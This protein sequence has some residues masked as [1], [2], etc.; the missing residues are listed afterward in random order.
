MSTSTTKPRLICNTWW[1]SGKGSKSYMQADAV[2]C[3]ATVQLQLQDRQIGYRQFGCYGS[4]DVALPC[5]EAM[6]RAPNHMFEIIRHGMMCKPYLDLDGPEVPAAFGGPAAGPHKV[7]ERASSLVRRIFLD[8]YGITLKPNDTIWLLSP[9]P[10]KLSLHLIIS[11]HSPQYVYKSNHKSDPG[12]AAHLAMRMKELDTDLAPLIDISVYSKDREMRAHRAFKYGKDPSTAL[13]IYSPPGTLP[14]ASERDVFITCLDDDVSVINVPITM[15][16]VV[17]RQRRSLRSVGEAMQRCPP[18]QHAECVTRMMDLLQ[19]HLHPTAYYDRGH[20]EEDPFNPAIAIKFNYHDRSELCYTGS[21]HAGC[22]NLRCWVDSCGDVHCKCFSDRCANHLPHRLGSLRAERDDYIAKA[23]CVNMEFIE[24]DPTLNDDRGPS[25]SDVDPSVAAVSRALHDWLNGSVKALSLRS[26]MGSGKT[27]FLRA[28]FLHFGSCF[29]TAFFP[30]YRQS[31]ASEHARKMEDH[32]FVS[33]LDVRRNGGPCSEDEAEDVDNTTYTSGDPLSDRARYPRVICSVE[34]MYR[35]ASEFEVPTF[36][37]VV[38]DESESL[39]RHWASKTVKG[40]SARM[41]WFI[42]MLCRARCIVMLDATWGALSHEFLERIGLSNILIINNRP[43]RVPRTFAFSKDEEA[44][45]GNIISDLKAGKKVAVA[46]L[47]AEHAYCLHRAVLDA[48]VS[49][50]LVLLHTSKTADN[51]R[52]GLRNVDALWSRYI[53]VIY[54]P[55]IA[56]GVDFSVEHFDR[57]YFY[58]CAGSALP[59]TALQMLFRVRKLADPAVSCCVSRTMR[60]GLTASSPALTSDDTRQW[61]LWMDA[62]M[63][64][65]IGGVDLSNMQTNFVRVSA[66]QGGRPQHRLL[67]AFTPLMGVLSFV[68]AE[69]HNA[70]KQYMREFAVLAEAGG[71]RV[72]T[73]ELPAGPPPVAVHEEEEKGASTSTTVAL[74]LEAHTRCPNPTTNDIKELERRLHYGTASA[75]DKWLHYV[76]TYKTNWGLQRLD[77]KFLQANKTE[78]VYPA[79]KTME[80]LLCPQHKPTRIDKCVDERTMMLRLPLV[81]GVISA[82]GLASPFDTDTVIPD[83]MAVFNTRVKETPM[84]MDYANNAKLFYKGSKGVMD[85]EWD[86]RKAAKSVNMVLGAV[87]LK[88]KPSLTKRPRD[89]N[90][91]Q[92]METSNYRLD[93]TCAAEMLELTRLHMSA[94]RERW[95]A[96]VCNPH[97]RKALAACTLSKYGH[98][99]PKKALMPAEETFEMEIDD[100]D[101]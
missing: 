12:G 81:E 4:W 29:K 68:E 69:R 91:R 79:T 59:A 28:L 101:G 5:L 6:R 75:D 93:L 34:S 51:I 47:S 23:L 87:G 17:A 99:A 55:T 71:H 67:P 63:R 70:S 78:A 15:P 41:D 27:Q 76:E 90:G 85:N 14:S 37:V 100:L 56:A 31:L 84:F 48:G 83:L 88:L 13:A 72:I 58:A 8:D 3:G 74:M 19:A 54:T 52:R 20:G 40:P 2:A 95:L 82:L 38:L 98:L 42:N 46:S 89:T 1:H 66:A 62:S 92:N 50:D 32:G 39:L 11:T 86:L 36:D 64:K 73:D 61:L 26:P 22:Q 44:W 35:L 7:I 60:F 53:L 10:F 21:T 18:E 9:N 80:W 57:M 65:D 96:H 16:D 25:S 43:P 45:Q 94:R 33:Y 24:F 77:A 97:A 30:T 49:P